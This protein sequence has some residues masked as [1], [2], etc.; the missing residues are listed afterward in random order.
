MGNIINGMIGGV[1]SE[2]RR[3]IEYVDGSIMA[4]GF[5]YDVSGQFFGDVYNT[6]VNIANCLMIGFEF[7]NFTFRVVCK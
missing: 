1:A 7:V 2:D 3:Y 5:F 4:D 6:G